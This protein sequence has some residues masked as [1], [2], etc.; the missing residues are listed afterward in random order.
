MITQWIL[1]IGQMLFLL[2]VVMEHFF[3]VPVKFYIL[4]NQ[5]LVLTLILHSLMDFYVYRNGVLP[6]FRQLLIFSYQNIFKLSNTPL[7]SSSCQLF[8]SSCCPSEMK[9]TL[10]PVFALNEV[11]AGAASSACVSDYDIS[12]DSGETIERQKSSGL[13]ISTGTGSTSWSHQINKLSESN[14]KKLFDLVQQINP[15]ILSNGLLDHGTNTSSVGNSNVT[16]LDC[17]IETIEALYNKSF[18]FNP[19][20][21]QMMYTVRDPL[22]N[23]VFKVTKP[24]GFASELYIRSLMDDGHL[25]FDSGVT[26]PF[27]S[28][29]IA[30]FT[31]LPSD[32][33]CCVTFNVPCQV[34]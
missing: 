29:S 18:I 32:A 7:D 14:I 28:G 11:F 16:K 17:L 25:A 23:G 20:D 22:N 26:F 31:V 15:F 33:L 10:L 4:I 6:M 5:L 19:E 8:P 12:V 27:K 13:V 9:T 21:C 30:K 1:L 3:L 2:L 24:H 34:N